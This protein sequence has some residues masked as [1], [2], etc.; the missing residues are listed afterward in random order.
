MSAPAGPP[1][2]EGRLAVGLVR[3]LHGLRGG[4]RVEVLT[5]DA[6]RFEP[7]SVLL[8]ADSDR[9]L[10]VAESHAD[11]PPGLIVR[12][13]ELPS[14]SS[15]EWLRERYLEV[16]PAEPLPAATYYWHE[17][18]GCSVVTSDGEPLGEVVD[19]FRVGEAEVYDVRGERGDLLVP[20]V[21]SVVRELVPAERR[22]VVD[23]AAL[24]LPPPRGAGRR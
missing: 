4:V 14:R 19:V 24:D 18:V 12:F 3:G 21:G 1:A 5:D 17:I 10:T 2:G 7:G 15:A 8:V 16:V 11:K 6:S 9:R 13:Q 23:A 20:A 22:I